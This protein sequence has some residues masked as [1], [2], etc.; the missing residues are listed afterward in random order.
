MSDSTLDDHQ[1]HCKDF[2]D[3]EREVRELLIESA[4]EIVRLGAEASKDTTELLRLQMAL[5][6][7]FVRMATALDGRRTMMAAV[8]LNKINRV[9]G[10]K[11]E[12]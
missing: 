8:L 5:D 4:V 11:N 3:S 7:A 10:Y 6:D 12:A 9:R 1:K 2:T